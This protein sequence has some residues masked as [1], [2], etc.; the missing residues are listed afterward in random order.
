MIL[1]VDI[2]EMNDLALQATEV[3]PIASRCGV[4]CK[5]DIQNL[6][7][8]NVSKANIAASI[9][10]AVA[11]QTVVTLAHG[12]E[13]SAP[14]V[15]CG[16]PLSYFSALRK[17]F[18]DYLSL[19]QES[20]IIP[21][22]STL[23]PAMG[24]AYTETEGAIFENINQFK[25]AIEHG[26]QG[27]GTVNHTLG[28][29]F[30][31]KSEYAQWKEKMCLPMA[32]ATLSAGKQEAYL[33]I[34]SGS[35]TTK[36][37]LIDSKHRLLYTDYGMNNGNPIMSV[38]RGLQRLDEE[39]KAHGTELIIRGASSTGYGGDFIRSAFVTVVGIVSVSGPDM[40]GVGI[41]F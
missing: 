21:N 22:H 13:I 19:D 40:V 35:T 26:I 5:T 10:R 6:I 25:V 41:G 3:Y 29:L 4:F 18:V 16:G 7:A 8:K 33:G 38:E 24:C 20:V 36:I 1:G 34:D 9:F 2:D 27:R 30:R 31:D 32:C 14:V 15:F 39:C 17:A 11:V 23:L 28:S 12:E 37:V